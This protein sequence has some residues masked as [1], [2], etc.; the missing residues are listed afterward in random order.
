M[1]LADKNCSFEY[2]E[3]DEAQGGKYVQKKA[4]GI[5][6]TE[7]FLKKTEKGEYM[8]IVVQET[9]NEN[10]GKIREVFANGVTVQ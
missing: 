10:K 9:S 3:K 1:P 4:N 8:M 2:S 5:I 7:P 6:V